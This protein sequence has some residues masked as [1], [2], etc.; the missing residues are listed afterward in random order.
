MGGTG[1]MGNPWLNDSEAKPVEEPARFDSSEEIK[2]GLIFNPH[3]Q[4]R[5]EEIK[6]E[7]K[8]NSEA[9]KEKTRILNIPCGCCGKTYSECAIPTNRLD[10]EEKHRTIAKEYAKNGRQLQLATHKACRCFAVWNEFLTI[11]I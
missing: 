6:Q 7:I 10:C 5:L 4:K 11:S 8:V 1:E 9:L 3:Q 2:R